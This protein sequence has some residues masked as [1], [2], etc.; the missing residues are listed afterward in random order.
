MGLPLSSRRT[1]KDRLSPKQRSANMR[2]IRA[3]GTGPERIVQTWINQLGHSPEQHVHAIPGRPDFVFAEASRIVLVYGDFWHGWRFPAWKGRLP[4]VYWQEKI[5][6]NRRRDRANRRKL[7]RLGWKILVIWEHQIRRDPEA[8][9][10]V[11]RRF[12]D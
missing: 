8:T 12:L 10:A 6:R 3:F 9:I 11:L 4:R 5:E 1:R 7:R 2:A